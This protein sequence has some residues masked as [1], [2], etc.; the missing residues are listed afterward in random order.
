MKEFGWRKY[1]YCTQALVLTWIAVMWAPGIGE[2]TRQVGIYTMGG[3]TLSFAGF[4]A[5]EHFAKRIGVN[6]KPKAQ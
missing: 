2:A 3:I 6:V 1:L 4:N 5:A